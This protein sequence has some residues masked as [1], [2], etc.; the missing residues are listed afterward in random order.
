MN[1]IKF[2][3]EIKE[4]NSNYELN[5]RT[6]FMDKFLNYLS[7]NEPFMF[8]KW[9]DGEIGGIDKVGFVAARGDQ[10]VGKELHDKLIWGISQKVDN[11]YIGIPCS[12]C[13]PEYHNLSLKYVDK[14]SEF[15]CLATALTNKAWKPFVS[16]FPDCI[17]GKRFH[18]ICGDDQDI[19][20]FETVLDIELTSCRMVPK[21]NG[22]SKYNE[23]S[24]AINDFQD[25][26]IIGLSCGPVSRV[27]AAEWFLQNKTLTCLD[28]GSTF[29]PFSRNVWH[30]CHLGTLPLCNECN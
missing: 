29:D 26:D 17:K 21:R 4:S 30:R 12:V 14:S 10:V 25:G 7:N 9:N 13:Y 16:L 27:L 2:Y 3:Q 15:V 8:G 6:L 23:I 22:W 11:Y 19:S 18:W 5:S 24:K 1:L 28:L 20:I